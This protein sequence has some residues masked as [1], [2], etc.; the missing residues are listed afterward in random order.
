MRLQILQQVVRIVI[1]LQFGT[2]LV[3]VLETELD[4]QTTVDGHPEIR[5][6]ADG[7][8]RHENVGHDTSATIYRSAD[9][10]IIDV[11]FVLLDAVLREE[12]AMFIAGEDIQFVFFVAT[13]VVWFLDA[14]SRWGVITGDGQTDSR[15]VIELDGLLN[16]AFTKGTASDDG[17]AVVVLNG[18]G[19]DFAGRCRTLVEEDDDRHFLT[20]SC[21]VRR[22]VF[23]RSHTALGVDYQSSFRQEFIHHL[24]GRTHVTTGV[25]AQVNDDALAV[26][27][28]QLGQGYQ[29]F[30]ISRFAELVDFDV[31]ELVVQHI[32]GINALD[33]DIP[34][35]NG[36]MQ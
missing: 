30:G 35:D 34:T 19:K 20:A 17:T 23:T 15:P 2:V 1:F 27:L 16:Q 11:A 18:S 33:W 6:H 21:A 10:G 13:L 22:I 29:H 26:L 28:V 9:G 14:T 7:I 8:L 32:G 36:E 24:N 4:G 31:T 12:F 25:P 5:G 3:G